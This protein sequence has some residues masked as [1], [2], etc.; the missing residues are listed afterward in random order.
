MNG[1]DIIDD[2]SKEKIIS[3]IS[4]EIE[5]TEDYGNIYNKN[6]DPI[7]NWIKENID[8]ARE[9]TINKFIVIPR[10]KTE[11]SEGNY[12]FDDFDL[13]LTQFT[14]KP[15]SN[16]IL[17]R[18][19]IDTQDEEKIEGGFINFD[20]V[21][22]S[23]TL[24]EVLR[25]KSEINYEKDNE[26]LFKLIS[27]L[28]EYFSSQFGDEGMKNVVMMYKKELVDEIYKQMLKHFVREEGL[29]KEEVFVDNPIN[30]QNNYSF[31]IIKN[32]F[33]PYNSERDGKI[34]SILFDGIIKGVFSSAK[35]DSE[36]EL[37]LAR[38]LER[39]EDLVKAWLRPAP[40]EFNI[41]YN[42]G[43]KY[44]PDFVVETNSVVYLVE[45]KADNQMEDEDVLAKKDRAVSYCELVSKWA[46][47]TNNKPWKYLLIP[48]SKISSNST[49]GYLCETYVEK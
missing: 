32:I 33:D 26:L 4:N 46:F 13:D 9:E 31:K 49:F 47:D 35:F 44:E 30:Y 29:I 25:K 1:I 20:A 23:K 36:P 34:T 40:S 27:S 22:P 11:Y 43:K 18:N 5:N 48:A 6:K 21:N 15:I 8:K 7:E 12:Y 14:Q 45:V 42:N 17:M 2:T 41:T 10:L 38:Q 24:V 3:T 28:I 37:I 16:D 39:E 19:L